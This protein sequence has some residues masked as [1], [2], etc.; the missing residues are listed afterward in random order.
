MQ[1]GLTVTKVRP[2]GYRPELSGRYDYFV[3]DGYLPEALPAAPVLVFDPPHPNPHCETTAP[4]RPG[5]LQAAAHPLAAYADF[6]AVTLSYAKALRGGRPLLQTAEGNVGVELERQGLPVVVFGFAVQGGDLPLRPAFPVLIR[7]VIDY[8][9]GLTAVP[10]R[11]RYGEP[12]YL[13]PPWP[14][15]AVEVLE[16]G[17]G[18]RRIAGPFPYRGEPVRETGIYTVT[19]GGHSYPVAINVPAVTDTLS[20]ADRI[21]AAGEP[22]TGSRQAPGLLPLATPLLL[23]AFFVLGLEWWVDNRGY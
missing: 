17:G 8:F 15:E 1:P 12:V 10:G 20:V 21:Y 19:A 6:S 3:F 14:V 2:A 13:D 7:N 9:T 16:P 11:L 5:R 18:R 23:A 4:F 22:V